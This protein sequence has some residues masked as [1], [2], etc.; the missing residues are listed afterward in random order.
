MT[1]ILRITM[2]DLLYE[3]AHR[4]PE[5]EAL[6][7]V[8]KEKGFTYEKFLECV[9]QL[10]KSFLK[11]GIKKGDHLAL[12]APNQFE[13]IITR[14]IKFVKEFPV[15]PLG[16]IQKFKLREIATKEYGLK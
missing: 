16:K 13:W 7:D 3:V 4:F 8:S 15:T 11:L 14:Y 10:S 5:N 9:N 12:W 6:I 1:D 2:G